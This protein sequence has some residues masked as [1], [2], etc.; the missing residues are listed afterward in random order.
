M[1]EARKGLGKKC[2]A[3]CNRVLI[4]VLRMMVKKV[5]SARVEVSKE[6]Y[7]I[8]V[9]EWSAKKATRLYV[10]LFENLVNKEHQ[11]VCL[12]KN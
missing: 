5:E 2:C 8:A 4:K 10:S 9:K 7:T 6:K 3:R 11:L 1:E 12:E